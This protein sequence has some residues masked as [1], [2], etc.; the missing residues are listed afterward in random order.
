LP[1]VSDPTDAAEIVVIREHRFTGSGRTD[2][3]T[4]DGVEI[5]RLRVGEHVVMRG[6]W[7]L[8][9]KS[10]SMSVGVAK[11]GPE[12]RRATPGWRWGSSPK[13]KWRILRYFPAREVGARGLVAMARDWRAIQGESPKA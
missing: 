8:G 13:R 5:Y 1:T 4:L 3:I 9:A 7:L 10:D 11:P 6:R 2:P 12:D